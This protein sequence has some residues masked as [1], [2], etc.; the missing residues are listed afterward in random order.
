[1]VKTDGNLL[2][3]Y[4]RALFKILIPLKLFKSF[5]LTYRIEYLICLEYALTVIFRK[6]VKSVRYRF[7]IRFRA[8]VELR[9]VAVCARA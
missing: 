5:V 2:G 8:A 3:P 4:V 6:R 9:Y 1:M 7:D